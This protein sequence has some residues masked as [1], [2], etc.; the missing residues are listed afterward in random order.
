MGAFVLC[1]TAA[2]YAAVGSGRALIGLVIP[3]LVSMGLAEIGIRWF[4]R[5]VGNQLGRSERVTQFSR[6][7]RLLVVL[8]CG[9]YVMVLLSADLLVSALADYPG[10]SGRPAQYLLVGLVGLSLFLTLV[11]MVMDHVFAVLGA[12]SAGTLAVGWFLVTLDAGDDV[13]A[14]AVVVAAA[15]VA[16]LLIMALRTVGH[17]ANHAFT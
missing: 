4:Q 12:F 16:Y 3:L 15:V 2:V 11:L 13:V 10:L 5:A 7:T 9:G 1:C 17:P 6:Q 8:S 14:R